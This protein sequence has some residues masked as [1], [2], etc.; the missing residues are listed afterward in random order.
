MRG[1]HWDFPAEQIPAEQSDVGIYGIT[2]ALSAMG[3][4]GQ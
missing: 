1:E 3:A 4:A 2:L